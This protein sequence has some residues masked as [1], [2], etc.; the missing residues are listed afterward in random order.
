MSLEEITLLGI[1]AFWFGY[2]IY[3]AIYEKDE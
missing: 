2:M 3:V 1:S